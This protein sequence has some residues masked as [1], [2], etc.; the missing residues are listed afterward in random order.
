MCSENFGAY[1][2]IQLCQDTQTFTLE[3]FLLQ[4]RNTSVWS[5]FVIGLAPVQFSVLNEFNVRE[6]PKSSFE[7][8]ATHYLLFRELWKIQERIGQC[9]KSKFMLLLRVEE[10]GL[11]KVLSYERCISGESSRTAVVW[12][13]TSLPKSLYSCNTGE[14]V[15]SP[16]K[17]SAFYVRP[18]GACTD[19]S[20]N[21]SYQDGERCSWTA[22]SMDQC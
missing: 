19:R 10:E 8:E 4:N 20:V 18:T 11:G 17:G 3:D 9:R 2:P 7:R 6:T 15:L 16:C 21:V 13:T 22:A 5:Y 12:S 14:T 1:F